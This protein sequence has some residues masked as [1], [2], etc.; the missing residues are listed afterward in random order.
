MC[1]CTP[2]YCRAIEKLSSLPLIQPPA[3]TDSGEQR[4]VDQVRA[5]LTRLCAVLMLLCGHVCFKIS[6]ILAL[7]KRVHPAHF[8]TLHSNFWSP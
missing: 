5:H 7:H 4:A 8:C 2:P 6:M 3:P 1:S